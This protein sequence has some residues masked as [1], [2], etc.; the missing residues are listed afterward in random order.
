M[1][2]KIN[3]LNVFAAV[4][5]LDCLLTIIATLVSP[6]GPEIGIVSVIILMLIG[7]L[8]LGKQ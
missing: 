4:Y 7:N 1:R 3:L 5:L 2:K 6:W 8:V